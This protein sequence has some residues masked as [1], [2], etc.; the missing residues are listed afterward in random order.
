[1]ITFRLILFTCECNFRVGIA[2]LVL[3]GAVAWMARVS[4]LAEERFFSWHPALGP[5]HPTHWVLRTL[6][7]GLKQPG[8]EAEVRN[9]GA[10]Y[11]PPLCLH[12]IVLN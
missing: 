12:G 11:P 5:T 10:I 1:V 3:R 6:S 8:Y 9:G 7:Q 2:Q 4:F